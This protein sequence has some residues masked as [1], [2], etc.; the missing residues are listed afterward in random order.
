MKKPSTPEYIYRIPPCGKYDIAGMESWLE[1]MAEKGY[2]LDRDGVFLGIAIFRLEPAKTARYRLEATATKGGIFSSQTDPEEEAVAFHQD[3][4][5]D[6]CGRWGQFWVYRCDDPLAPELHTD[7][8]VQAL[9][10]RGL[11][12]LQRQ[13]FLG[14]LCYLLF[15]LF[16]IT[17]G[18]SPV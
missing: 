13:N 7:P 3:M 18:F 8:R 16:C 17:C 12:R 10:F 11:T 9:S 5:W 2:F 1:D 4:G 14:T 15:N 6:Y